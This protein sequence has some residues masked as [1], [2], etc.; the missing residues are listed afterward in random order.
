MRVPGKPKLGEFEDTKENYPS[1]DITWKTKNSMD[2]VYLHKLHKV[3]S[4][5]EADSSSA[6]DKFSPVK[7]E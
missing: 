1:K 4:V 7:Q 3:Q 2:Q 5:L 6:G